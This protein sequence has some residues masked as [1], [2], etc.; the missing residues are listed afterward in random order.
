MLDA[1]AGMY[2]EAWADGLSC[3]SG[4]YRCLDSDNFG[5]SGNEK[6]GF[7]EHG[8]CVWS[9]RWDVPRRRDRQFVKIA[10]RGSIEVLIATILWSVRK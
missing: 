6:V 7:K 8:M 9:V 5:C 4:F 3:P 1:S 10:L 2:Q